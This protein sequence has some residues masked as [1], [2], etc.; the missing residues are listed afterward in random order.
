MCGRYLLTASM[1]KL[2]HS[3]GFEEF[4]DIRIVPRFNVAPSQTVPVVRNQ[5]GDELEIIRRKDGAAARE[6]VPARWGLIPSWAKDASIGY[7]TINARAEGI[8]GKPAFRDAYRRR[9][10]I[11]P[12]SGFYEWRKRGGPKQPHLIRRRD[13]EPIGF[14][15]L[16]ESWTDRATG[17][18]VTS[19]T[20]VT[21]APNELMAELHDRMPVILD[22][23]D[24]DAW[25]DPTDPRGSELLRA[26]PAEWLEAVPVSARVNSPRNDD[27]GIVEPEG[28]PLPRQAALL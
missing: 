13:G 12:A 19:C 21:T 25:L 7:K 24:Y 9:R 20:I 17:E 2:G 16:W 14:A 1:R 4:S 6:L 18:V 22:P 10:C 11:V 15:G 26:C 23:V 28:E 8:A 5:V 27:P 3:F